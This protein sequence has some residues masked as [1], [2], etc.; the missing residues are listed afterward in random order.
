MKRHYGKHWWMV[1]VVGLL[2]LA[3]AFGSTALAGKKKSNDDGW[4]GVFIHEVDE[5]T[6]EAQG[7]EADDGVI[8]DDVIE[9]SPAEKAGLESGDVILKF[10]G[11]EVT[12]SGRLTR[13]IRKTEPDTEVKLEIIRD[14]EPLEI[15]ATIGKHEGDYG[16]FFSDDDDDYHFRGPRVFIPPIDIPHIEIPKIDIPR[17]EVFHDDGDNFYVSSSR[18]RIGVQLRGLNEQLGEYFGVADGE[19]ALVEKVLED[20]PAEDAGIKAGDVIVKIDGE[21]VGD[22]DDVVDEIR[23]FDEGDEVEITVIRNGAEKKFAVTIEEDEFDSKRRIIVDKYRRPT[24]SYQTLDWHDDA[25]DTYDEVREEL[26]EAMEELRQEME[27]VREELKEAL[28][29]LH[30]G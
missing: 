4:L 13:W 7:L 11:K 29:E 10:D 18:G 14:G 27:E 2:A 9:D 12:S 19:G 21:D 26:R 16:Y 5:D 6:Q 17:I 22:V 3:V 20:S 24:R 25:E 30:G 15:T 1:V 8:I 23:N 28:E